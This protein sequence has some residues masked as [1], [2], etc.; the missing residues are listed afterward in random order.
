[1]HSYQYTQKPST[2]SPTLIPD[3][4]WSRSYRNHLPSITLDPDQNTIK[5]SYSKPGVV[6]VRLYMGVKAFPK[7]CLKVLLSMTVSGWSTA[8]KAHLT[9]KNFSLKKK[10]PAGKS[11]ELE[12]FAQ[13][14]GFSL[15]LTQ[16]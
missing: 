5:S 11:S 1:M 10:P 14:F 4:L 15:P 6:V 13:V 7:N 9:A 2:E 8:C 3:E 12:A 16:W